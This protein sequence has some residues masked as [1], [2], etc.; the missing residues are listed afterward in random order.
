MVSVQ[1]GKVSGDAKPGREDA[2]RKRRRND[3][4]AVGVVKE[5]EAGTRRGFPIARTSARA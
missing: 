2:G 1:R 5:G 4:R 3:G